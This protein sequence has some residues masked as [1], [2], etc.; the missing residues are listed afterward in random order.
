MKVGGA[1]KK[2]KKNYTLLKLSSFV[3]SCL[4]VDVSRDLARVKTLCPLQV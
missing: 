2:I 1:Y 4:R 3:Y